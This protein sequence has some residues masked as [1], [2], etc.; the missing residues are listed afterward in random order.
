MERHSLKIRS[1]WLTKIAAF[2]AVATCHLLFKTCRK[3]FIGV[4]PVGRMEASDDP[5]AEENFV[6]C[7]WHDALLLPTFATPRRLREQCCCLVSQH[8]DGSYLAEAMAWMGY[9]TVRGSSKRGGTEALRE[10][11]NDTAGKHIII[12]PDGP[13]GPRRQL[14]HGAVFIAA[15]T[16]RRLLPGAFVVQRGWRIQGSWTDLLIPMPFTTI[17]VVTGEPIA[18]PPDIPRPELNR[19][20]AIVQRAMDE[21]DDK[22]EQMIGHRPQPVEPD[23]H[24]AA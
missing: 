15:Q 2:C 6:L 7:V 20:V 9:T 12:T 23:K 8:Q 10:L 14:K 21:L 24:K 4:V 11:V 16:G 5:G 17:Y 13:R 19:Y 22:A 3:R 1:R 18:V